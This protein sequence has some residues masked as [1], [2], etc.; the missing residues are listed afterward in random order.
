MSLKMLTVSAKRPPFCFGLNVL[1]I[2]KAMR[3]KR[4]DHLYSVILSAEIISQ[5]CPSVF[6]HPL[7]GRTFGCS[8]FP[9]KPFKEL[10]WN[11]SDVVIMGLSWIDQPF[12]DATVSLKFYL[13]ALP[14][15]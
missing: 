12:D 13:P 2:S 11:L 5:A 14:D 6:V 9:H 15:C 4:W 8:R 10:T 7:V 1:A 3:I